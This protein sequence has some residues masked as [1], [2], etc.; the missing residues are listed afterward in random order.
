M[1]YFV[2][3]C[4]FFAFLGGI[5]LTIVWQWQLKRSALSV[6]RTQANAKGRLAQTEQEGELMA[7]MIDGGNA[8]KAA[9]ANGQDMAKAAA[10]IVPGLVA[11]YPH[12]SMKYGKKL[13]KMFNDG[14]GF[15]GLEDLF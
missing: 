6:V 14:G 9:K 1:D 8:F 7:M 4:L 2:I 3:S 11:K 5:G 13:F 10:E 15:E 12:A